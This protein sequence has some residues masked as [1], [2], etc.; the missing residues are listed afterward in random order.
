MKKGILIGVML[1]SS[2]ILANGCKLPHDTSNNS[3][4]SLEVLNKK[5]VNGINWENHK[6]T[7]SDEDREIDSDNMK[8]R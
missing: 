3:I 5:E 1:L 7:R 4:L 8:N 6:D 2:L